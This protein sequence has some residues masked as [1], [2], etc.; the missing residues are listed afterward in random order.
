MADD[1]LDGAE[2]SDE[3]MDDATRATLSVWRFRLGKWRSI[4]IEMEP[5]RG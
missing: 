4:R 5:E 1:R 3:E 2:V